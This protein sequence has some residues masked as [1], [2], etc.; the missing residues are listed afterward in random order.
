MVQALTTINQA[1]R[2][3]LRAAAQ[4]LAAG[5]VRSAQGQWQSAHAALQIVDHPALVK[6]SAALGAVIP[7]ANPDQGIAAADRVPAFGAGATALTDYIG[8][9][10][11]GRRDQ[12]LRLWPAYQVLQRANGAAQPFESDLFFPNLNVAPPERA[13]TV[14]VA[15]LTADELRN[16][17]RLLETGLLQWLR[18]GERTGLQQIHDAVTRVEAAQDN[19]HARRLWWVAL[20]V[21]DALLHDGL[22]ADALARRLITQLNLHLG[23]LLQGPA[24]MADAPEAL[25]RDALFLAARAQPQ[26]STPRVAEVQQVCGLQGALDI[27]ET[28][29]SG[30]GAAA[31]AHARQQMDGLQAQWSDC[32]SGVVSTAAFAEKA[33]TLG[34][35]CEALGVPALSSLVAQIADSAHRLSQPGATVSDATAIEG[36]C[37]LLMVERALATEHA[38]DDAFAARAH[39]MAARLKV[40]VESPQSPQLL[41]ALPPAQ[42][43]D[44][45]A[46]QAQAVEHQALVYA[47]IERNLRDIE[48]ALE[49]WF[50]NLANLQ[51]IAALD[52]PFRQIQGA[53]AVLGHADAAELARQCRADATRYAQGV[54]C[55]DAEGRLLSRRLTALATFVEAS[56]FGPTTLQSVLSRLSITLPMQ[57]PTSQQQAPE[58]IVATQPA[59]ATPVAAVAP[60]APMAAAAAE[61]VDVPVDGAGDTDPEMLEIFL[62]EAGEVLSTLSTTVAQSRAQPEDQE[63]L[64]TLRRAFHTLK[65]SGRMVGLK[66]IGEA[67]WEMEQ[68]MNDRASQQQPGTP[69]LYRLIDYAQGRFAHWIGE[70]RAHRQAA[71]DAVQLTDWARKLRAG[72]ALPE[73]LSETQ[74]A[75]ATAP[76]LA[77]P[78]PYAPVPVPV[79]EPVV[80]L[81]PAPPPEPEAPSD[82]V[83]VGEIRVSRALYD[84]ML[85]EARQNVAVLE[86]QNRQMQDG[87]PIAPPF[88]RAAHTLRGISGTAGFPAVNALAASLEHALE[89]AAR[90]N[91]APHPDVRALIGRAVPALAEQVASIAACKAPAQY[92]D[93]IDALNAVG[94]QREETPAPVP[95]PEVPAVP[96]AKAPLVPDTPAP[97]VEVL[98]ERAVT[99][100]LTVQTLATAGTLPLA[101]QPELVAPTITAAATVDSA[102]VTAP[103]AITEHAPGMER[104]RSRLDNDV[105]QQLLP[106]F[107][108]EAAELVPQVGQDLR[109]WRARPEDKLVAQSLKRL[110]HT[111]KGSARMAGAMAL[112]Q[113]TH[114]MESRIENAQ[115]L[116]SIPE[117]LID[118]LETSFD[119]IG[120][121]IGQLQ[122]DGTVT[123]VMEV[124]H[125]TQ[126]MEQMSR[127]MQMATA[128]GAMT[129]MIPVHSTRD[130]DSIAGQMPG[131]PRPLI[132]VRAD[133]ID[134]LAN[135]AGEVSIARARV[136]TELRSARGSLRD[137][138]DNVT[139]LRAQLRELE[140]Q[141]ETQ[142]QSRFSPAPDQAGGKFDPLEF[143][144][145][146]RLQELTR[147]MAESV[148]DVATVQ[149]SLAR[150]LDESEKALAAQAITTRDVQQD[151]MAIRMVQ[152]SSISDRLYRV[153]RLSAKDA[154]KRVALDILGEHVEVDRTVMDRIAAPIEHLL[155]NAI[156]HGIEAP[157][158]RLELGKPEAGTLKLEVRQ[159]GN[160]VALSLSDDGAGL[161]I[162]RIRE[163]AINLGMMRED[164]LLSDQQIGNF[165]FRSGFSTADAVTTEAGRGVGMDVVLSEITALGGR[166]NTQFERGKGTNFTIHLPLTLSVLQSVVMR[167]GDNYY[168]VPTMMV[169]Q[170]QRL[171]AE[172]LNAAIAAREIEWQGARYPFHHLRQLLAMEA[173][174]EAP[175][176]GA[177][178]LLRTGGHRAAIQV[179]DIVGGQEI[180]IKNIGAQLARVPGVTGAAVLGS[181]ETV[182]ILNPVLLTQRYFEEAAQLKSAEPPAFEAAAAPERQRNI[183]VVDDSLTVR[184]ITDRLLTR[185]GYKVVVAKDGI[186]ALEKLREQVPDVMITD[187][188]MPRMD[189]F[190]LTR[191][192]RAEV[193]LKNLPIIMIT[194]RTA[195]KHRQHATEL[196]VDV[197]LGKPYEE[198][199][200]LR[201][202]AAL[203][204]GQVAGKVKSV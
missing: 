95:E 100:G 28:A 192:V 20:A 201:Q 99:V 85:P 191:N 119:R 114:S 35:A 61:V 71:V 38:P 63:H 178:L 66:H 34:G 79:P 109:A 126:A 120:M 172:V 164:E 14:A 102:A 101:S 180:V 169:E 8:T 30:F 40:S 96:D 56:K 12:P 158:R 181:G 59:Y 140:I 9:L 92:T 103:I 73:S 31:L 198:S 90:V 13:A 37:A 1:V 29:P 187:V 134:R 155:R 32:A 67:A 104:R 152:F 160:E 17:R 121:L 36:A 76:T 42:F 156:V 173:S 5:D 144:R 166:V 165:I 41:K 203:A 11:A 125:L 202:I 197:F 148:N 91:A 24:A 189:G 142:M 110:L 179:D 129:Q 141:A 58:A 128:S 115:L 43:L 175:Q 146:T 55:D 113:L 4:A 168:A 94:T 170:V 149:H 89:H 188:E 186:E 65:G 3:A 182:L 39:N 70:L 26:P 22:V 87:A 195:E 139:R 154:E 122:D 137:L 124:A 106:I 52:K 72:E 2:D 143:D 163:K 88:V 46:L 108:E 157:K 185:E 199:E 15:P 7:G 204:R 33:R 47:E 136:S 153:S 86:V 75:V 174:E 98:P 193:A 10:V 50:G 131:I 151:L 23:R 176:Y 60:M 16:T 132:R 25:W 118:D 107:L 138:T 19:A 80:D 112:G 161:N 177:V 44:E 159:E 64:T 69:D 57:V 190:D 145:F 18:K 74:P 45:A 78:A 84:I 117:S 127:T 54:P 77:T 6:F 150:D 171:K 167:V 183:L 116:P 200:L 68:V 123:R 111:L 130:V 62:E 135:Q 194:S 147:L 162:E 51:L 97:A 82:S 81:V 133:L 184:K 49:T 105:D 83:M 21:L 53:F 93:L 27:A 48:T 196:G